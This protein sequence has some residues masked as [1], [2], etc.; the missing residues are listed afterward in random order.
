[1]AVEDDR[2]TFAI[3]LRQL[4]TAQAGEG[5]H[6]VEPADDVMVLRTGLDLAGPD[7]DGRH[8]VAT[9]AHGALGAAERRVAGVRIHV[10]PGAVVGGVDHQRVLV[11]AECA[12]LVH[13]ASDARVQLHHRI[14]VLGLG[15]RFELELRCRQVGLVHLHEVDI[16]E[17][18]L[19]RRL[20][21]LSRNS[22]AAFSTYPSKN[23]MPTT[24]SG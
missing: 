12:Q 13:D 20:G 15:Q 18:R 17:E 9:F 3:L 16:D 1:V 7:R 6:Q 5:R 21:R 4:H 11:Q 14:G 10:L 22:S 8:A 24:P 23:G 19:A 2:L